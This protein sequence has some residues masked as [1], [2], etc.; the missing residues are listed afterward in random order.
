[1]HDTYTVYVC[2]MVHTKISLLYSLYCQWVFS[3]AMANVAAH[4]GFASS[5][6]M[7][8][9]RCSVGRKFWTT[10]NLM[11]CSRRMYVLQKPIGC[12]HHKSVIF[13]SVAVVILSH[14]SL[15]E[16]SVQLCIIGFII[17]SLKYCDKILVH[18][19]Q[20][21]YLEVSGNLT[22]KC[23]YHIRVHLCTAQCLVT[24]WFYTRA[25]TQLGS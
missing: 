16:A 11:D 18:I 24:I 21:V 19:L 22:K 2:T 5:S 7:M 15:V 8:I 23:T 13:W 1:M 12:C 3:V 17:N 10:E 9:S 14:M 4:A 25:M 6:T 20:Q